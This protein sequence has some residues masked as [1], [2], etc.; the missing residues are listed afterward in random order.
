ML[1]V[2]NVLCE[3]GE[4]VGDLA[5][6]LWRRNRNPELVAEIVRRRM[7]EGHL[8]L[9]LISAGPARSKVIDAKCRAS[10]DEGLSWVKEEK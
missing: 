10:T 6:K 5:G 2:S 1:D 9:S 7:A 3:L 4:A 8:E